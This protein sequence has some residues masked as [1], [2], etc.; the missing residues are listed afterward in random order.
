M[1]GSNPRHFAAGGASGGAAGGPG[2]G[3]SGEVDRPWLALAALCA[4]F[5]MIMLDTT[6][7][8]IAIPAM[9]NGLNASLS[10]VIWIN[11]VYLLTYAVPLLLTGRLGDRFGPKRLFLGGLVVFT[12]ASAACGFAGSAA[13]LI[14]AR[15]VQGLGA[16]AMTPQTMAF[17][18]RLFPPSRRGAPMGLWGAVAGVATITGPLLGGVLVQTL[19]WEWIF[20]VNVP[21]GVLAI[22]ATIL[23]V[24]DWQPRHSHRFDPIGIALSSVGLLCVVFGLQEGQRYDWGTIAG[25]VTVPEIIGAGV[26]LLVAFMVWQRVNRNEPLLPLAVFGHR[27]FSMSNLANITVGFT[28]AGMFLPLVIYIQSVLGYSAIM[29]GLITAPLS[30]VSGVVA[31]FA[32]RMSDRVSGKWIVAGGIATFALGIL[33]LTMLAHFDSTGWALTPAFVVAGLGVGCI[34]S[35][36]ANLATSG[37]DPRLIGAGSGIF[38]T[39]RQVGGVIGSAAIG[40]LLQARLAVEL[41]AQAAA[42][43]AKLP[44][45]YREQF[46]HAFARAA[47]GNGDFSSA[48]RA[49]LPP[50]IPAAAADQLRRLGASV[51]DHAFTAAMRT[52]L[53]LPVVVL[54]AGVVACLAMR[55]RSYTTGRHRATS[56]ADAPARSR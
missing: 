35:P 36:L 52:T 18:T 54:A 7:V 21:I 38:N 13:T 23:L 33:M 5:F 42:A 40:V 26:L 12:L 49:P 29:S 19:G 46:E 56:D 43:A 31:P 14:A 11:S 17:V 45:A 6:I 28:M 39:S 16:A 8:N 9:I 48:A 1:S 47:A 15:A 24:P 55:P 37:L 30:F 27:N 2:G 22:T 41:P 34:F 25:P 50:G 51:F 10:E 32:G 20:F 3:A 4:G 44:A 53:L